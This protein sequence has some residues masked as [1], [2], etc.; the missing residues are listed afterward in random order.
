MFRSAAVF[1]SVQRGQA[2]P[3]S[4][5]DVLIDTNPAATFDLIDLVGLHNLLADRL[6]YPV[7]VVERNALRPHLREGILAEAEAVF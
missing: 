6:G 5:V 7:D 2:R 3:D 4:D 1:G